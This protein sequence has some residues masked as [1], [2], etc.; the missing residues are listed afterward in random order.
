MRPFIFLFILTAIPY[1]QL[2]AESSTSS[3]VIINEVELNPRGI[4]SYTSVTE[5]IELYN[6][7]NSIVD[8]GGWSVSSSAL[9]T[10]STS[11]RIP[12][13]I[14]I[15]AKGY[16][17]VYSGSFW[18]N[19]FNETVSLFDSNK[20]IV[21]QAG[22]FNDDYND[23]SSWQT[24]PDGSNNW[25]FKWNTKQMSNSITDVITVSNLAIVDQAGIP[26]PELLADQK[27]F[28]EFDLRNDT[29]ELV[30]LL[31]MIQI[32]DSNGFTQA[33]LSSNLLLAAEQ[34]FTVVQPWTPEQIGC[35]T[36]EIF[37]WQSMINPM[38][39]SHR[40]LSSSLCIT[41][42]D[43]INVHSELSKEESGVNHNTQE[44]VLTV[45]V[46]DRKTQ[47]PISEATVIVAK[48][49][50]NIVVWEITDRDGTQQLDV[51]SGDYYIIIKA[52]CCYSKMDNLHIRGDMEKIFELVDR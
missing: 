19:D 33:L 31:Y 17:L 16:L 42:H 32:K 36:V 4:D 40:P 43:V 28:F 34:K 45:K 22:P 8:V 7:S 15:P 51:P 23:G 52:S 30:E 39:L 5:W 13:G 44:N 20:K 21:N 25:I 10:R 18:L 48:K 6:T 29:R 37:V 49:S 50:G 12:E 46:V 26:Q 2:Q 1:Q 41:T 14:V 47:S 27:T 9:S 38:V 3:S 35:Y 24:V 11:I